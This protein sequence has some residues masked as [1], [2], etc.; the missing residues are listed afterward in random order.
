M[1]IWHK[2]D[3]LLHGNI[4]AFLLRNIS[5]VSSY[6]IAQ[7]GQ[8]YER[9]LLIADTINT[10]CVCMCICTWQQTWPHCDMCLK[11]DLTDM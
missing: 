4:E 11:S 10:A 3:A 9:V 6:P 2:K 5:E 8:I 7:L 1:L